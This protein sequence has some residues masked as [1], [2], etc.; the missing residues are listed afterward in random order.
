MAKE[1]VICTY[2]VRAGA[3]DAFRKLLAEHW[4]TLSELG[5]VTDEQPVVLRSVDAPTHEEISPGSTAGS[6]ARTSTSTC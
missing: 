6:G 1:T 2:R 5:F 3:E 4:A